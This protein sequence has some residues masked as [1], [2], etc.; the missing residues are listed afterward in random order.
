[1]IHKLF[2]LIASILLIACK[3]PTDSKMQKN[4]P[5]SR[6]DTWGYVGYGG[7]GAMF[8]PAVSPHNPD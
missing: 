2:F 4:S 8:N 1:M 6:N 7:G 5:Y 3:G